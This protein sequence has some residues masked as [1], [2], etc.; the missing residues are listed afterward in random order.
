MAIGTQSPLV[1]VVIWAISDQSLHRSGVYIAALVSVMMASLYAIQMDQEDPFDAAG[2]DDLNM[3]VLDEPPFFMWE[4]KDRRSLNATTPEKAAPSEKMQVPT[5]PHGSHHP[6]P[7]LRGSHSRRG[8]TTIP[9][10]AA[11]GSAMKSSNSANNLAGQS[12][13]SNVTLSSASSSSSPPSQGG[14]PEVHTSEAS[15]SS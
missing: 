2:V 3:H 10:P 8:T 7:S 14:I 1:Y 11:S 13:P 5:G 4:Q 15:S 6:P 9:N 12:S